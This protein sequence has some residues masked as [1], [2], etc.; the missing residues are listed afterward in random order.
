MKSHQRAW[1]RNVYMYAAMY[2]AAIT[3]SAGFEH[4]D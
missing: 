1:G 3:V 2:A 4:W